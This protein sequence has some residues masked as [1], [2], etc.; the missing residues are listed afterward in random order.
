M[1]CLCRKPSLVFQERSLLEKSKH[2]NQYCFRERVLANT[3]VSQRSSSFKHSCSL[4]DLLC[5]SAVQGSLVLQLVPCEMLDAVISDWIKL[6][7][8]SFYACICVALFGGPAPHS[9]GIVCKLIVGIVRQCA[10]G[11]GSRLFYELVYT[12]M[13]GN[14]SECLFECLLL[15]L[16]VSFRYYVALDNVSFAALSIKHVRLSIVAINSHP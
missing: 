11:I 7:L 16:L 2:N 6:R 4:S 1:Q 14:M 13:F 9:S 8:A 10:F 5:P 3:H 15:V 12:N